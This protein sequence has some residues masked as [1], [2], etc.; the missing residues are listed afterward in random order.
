MS[1]GPRGRS[2]PRERPLGELFSELTDNVR[3]LV[4]REVELAR[5]EIKEQ[6]TRATKGVTMFAGTG[7]TAFLA[8]VLLSFA[9]AWGL[10]ELIPVGF[11]FAVVGVLYA[12][13]A[14][15]L[16]VQGRKKLAAFSP[17]PQQTVET[18]KEDV[19]VAKES[20]SEGVS[21]DDSD[22]SRRWTQGGGGDWT[23]RRT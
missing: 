4:Q 5:I 23:T 19:Q 21:T 13:V 12:A 11:A 15:A 16:F 14:G 7:V 17:V 20:L 1:Q 22:L 2:Q 6:M 9:A 8:L 18:V 10:A 3:T